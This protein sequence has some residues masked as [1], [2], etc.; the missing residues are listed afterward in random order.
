MVVILGFQKE[1]HLGTNF[2][3]LF[4][5]P[6]LPDAAHSSRKEKETTLWSSLTSEAVAFQRQLSKQ[7]PP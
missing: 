3:I 1:T 5:R 4:P 7:A 2:T 6:S